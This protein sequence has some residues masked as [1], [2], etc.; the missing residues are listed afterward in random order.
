MR[1]ALHVDLGLAARYLRGIAERA[2]VIR[3]ERKVVSASRREDGCVEELK[4]EDG[5]SLRADLFVDCTGARAQLIGEILGTPFEDWKQWLPCDRMLAA[6]VALDEFRPPY[7]RVTARASGW[8]SRMPLQ[9]G[10][11]VCQAWSSEF[12]AEDAAREEFTATAGSPLAEPRLAQFAN[13]RRRSAWEKNVV[14][15][16][17]AAGFLEPLVGTDMHLLV[18]GLFGLLDHFPDRQFDPALI[19]SYNSGVADEYER[20]RDFIVLHF[21]TSRRDD[22]TFWQQRRSAAVPEMVAHRLAMYR[23]TGRIVH[24]RPEYF[25]DLDWFWIL[26]G[27]GIVPRDYDP[28]VDSV[29]FEQVKRLMSAIGQKVAADVA[30]AP[31]HDSF[32]AAANARLAGARKA[33][34]AAPSAG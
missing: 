5:G 25:T 11:T 29:D 23:A 17:H 7:V 3:L 19:A 26:E 14:A 12:Q 21:C 22:S 9:R 18:S 31:S 33:A 1:Y 16:G 8:Q 4:F 27:A 30:A 24:H 20:I 10:A 2:G 15:V 6:P 28:M 13:G 34:G 32:F